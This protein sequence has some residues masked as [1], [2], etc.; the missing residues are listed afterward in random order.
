MIT[1][2]TVSTVTTVSTIAAMGLTAVVSGIAI[3]AII[4][5]LATKELA[6]AGSSGRSIRIARY[7]SIAIVPLLIAFAVIMAVQI[8]EILA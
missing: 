6:G 2:V 3:A 5:F 1:T 7:T 8:F 4:F